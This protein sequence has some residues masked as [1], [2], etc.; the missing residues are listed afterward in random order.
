M[1]KRETL[2]KYIQKAMLQYRLTHSLTQEHM[3]EKL[4]ISTR[5]YWNHEHC[6]HG[7]SVFC[8]IS[9][10]LLLS[11]DEALDFIEGLRLFLEKGGH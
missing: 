9:F 8:V 5:A 2:S 10:L 6:K 3:A 7:L 1:Y 4:G 11:K